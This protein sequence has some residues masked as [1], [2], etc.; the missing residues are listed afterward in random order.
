MV[1]KSDAPIH[2]PSIVTYVYTYEDYCTF[3]G[4]VIHEY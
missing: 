4:L 1:N 3:Q 2:T